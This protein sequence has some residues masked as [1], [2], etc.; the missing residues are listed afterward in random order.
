MHKKYVLNLT[1]RRFGERGP[2]RMPATEV[3][4]GVGPEV[5]CTRRAKYGDFQSGRSG[6]RKVGF[7]FPSLGGGGGRATVFQRS[8]AGFRSPSRWLATGVI[9]PDFVD[10]TMAMELDSHAAHGPWSLE[11]GCRPASSNVPLPVSSIQEL[12]RANPTAL[13]AKNAINAQQ[14]EARRRLRHS[15]RPRIPP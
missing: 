15:L 6:E 10:L 8:L 13:L 4:S 3:T 11:Y 5:Y 14:R 2:E 9:Q 12:F 1:V 7:Q